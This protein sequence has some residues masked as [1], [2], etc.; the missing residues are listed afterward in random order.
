MRP[1]A[2]RMA[3]A[4]ALLA[5]AAACGGSP[6][7]PRPVKLGTSFELQP[8]ETVAVADLSLRLTFSR[9]REDSRCPT[10]AVCVWE[11]DAVA[12][13]TAAMDGREPAELALHTNGRFASQATYGG[14][15]VTLLG[16]A[17]YPKIDQ[18]TPPASYVATF[19]V[20]AAATTSAR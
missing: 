5:A 12:S 16:L 20:D 19:V 1:V 4:V 3:L 7:G 10:G 8:G 9:V 18:V 2:G 13:V 6:A 11:G 14:S 15:R 17:P